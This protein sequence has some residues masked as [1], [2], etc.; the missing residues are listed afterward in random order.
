MNFACIL[1]CSLLAA[2]DLWVAPSMTNVFPGERP[3]GVDGTAARI[4]AAQGEYE[5]F[6]LVVQ[7]DK[8]GATVELQST[9]VD[10][11]IPAPIISLVGYVELDVE[12]QLHTQPDVLMP[13]PPTV[14]IAPGAQAV[15][16]ITY[17]IGRDA[18][19]G[20]YSSTI[21]VGIGDKRAKR[22]PVSIE[23]LPLALPE[24][25]TLRT[26][27]A[28]DRANI[29]RACG[30]TDD[31]LES[32]K[33]VYDVLGR[34][35]ISYSMG[36]ERPL[37]AWAGDHPETSL[38]KEHLGYAV[39]NA[40]MNTIFVGGDDMLAMFPEP[41][42][43][44]LQDPL[45]LYLH[46]MGNWLQELGW[47]EQAM[48]LNLP[49]PDRANWQLH[50]RTYFRARRA[51]S[52]FPRMMAGGAHPFFERYTDAWALPMLHYNP[53]AHNRLAN[54]KSL[55]EAQPDPITRVTASNSGVT[56]DDAKMQ[57]IPEDA[58]DGSVYTSWISET[59]P[60]EQSPITFEAHLDQ[61]VTRKEIKVAWTAYLEPS[62][63]RVLTSPDGATWLDANVK[64]ESKPALNR[65]EVTT[66]FAFFRVERT[67][68]AI[69]FEFRGSEAGGPVG[70]AELSLKEATALSEEAIPPVAFWLS[71]PADGFPSLGLGRSPLDARILPWL[72]QNF[73]A[74]GFVGGALSHW[75]EGMTPGNARIPR[76]AWNDFLIYPAQGMVVPSIRLERLRD[77]MEDFEL[78]KILAEQL[79][80]FRV[81]VDR[82][83]AAT[84]D[85]GTKEL[86]QL[87]TPYL[88]SPTP[89]PALVNAA[90]AQIVAARTQIGRA[91]AREALAQKPKRTSDS[92][93]EDTP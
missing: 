57:T 60:G 33:P 27:F 18:Q 84:N 39:A 19:P 69:R 75:P 77:G 6:Q 61:P 83:F 72:C 66:A 11:A 25:P 93:Q 37:V 45:Q 12:G 4:L 65:F 80:D 29:A 35:R 79:P 41:P 78:L 63:V 71:T 38:L 7:A 30:I 90:A 23:V 68:M 70:I 42:V 1:S 40:K 10:A 8:K 28:L 88:Y 9:T 89:D 53:N 92:A 36:V 58:V 48:M 20:N 15:F 50:R 55:I 85:A 31:S 86:G 74:K 17:Y 67:F 87:L 44:T 5:S 26:L 51:D 54:G 13:L 49:I 52:R 34:Y 22:V 16:W 64:W 76:K 14:E 56:N 43:P 3:E 62:T 82:G 47:L 21:E 32:W 81:I 24:S 73:T 46:D 2:A 59:T 91:L